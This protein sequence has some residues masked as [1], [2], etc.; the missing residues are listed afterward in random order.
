MSDGD[1]DIM[2][3]S[4]SRLTA[5]PE[6]R[7][8]GGPRTREPAVPWAQQGRPKGT[9]MAIARPRADRIMCGPKDG[10]LERGSNARVPAG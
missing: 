9:R 7:R 3:A 8:G 6:P 10:W 4:R 5:G 1:R 2:K